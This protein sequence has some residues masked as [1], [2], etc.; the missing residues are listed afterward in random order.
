MRGNI[1]IGEM[2]HKMCININ[3][4]AHMYIVCEC[5]YLT[6]MSIYVYVCMLG[7]VPSTMRIIS[8]KSDSV[9]WTIMPVILSK[10]SSEGLPQKVCLRRY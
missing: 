9:V 5:K 8:G 10:E 4:P 6:Y 3:T 2:Q 7:T 1:L